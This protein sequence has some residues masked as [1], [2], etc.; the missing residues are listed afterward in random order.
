[1]HFE[2]LVRRLFAEGFGPLL[3]TVTVIGSGISAERLASGNS[4]RAPLGLAA[5]TS[6]QPYHWLSQWKNAYAGK[7]PSRILIA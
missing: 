3:V 6:T 2:S 1:M 7:T 5:L 4:V